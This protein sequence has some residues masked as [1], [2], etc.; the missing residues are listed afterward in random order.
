MPAPRPTALSEVCQTLIG[1]HRPVEFMSVELPGPPDR[2]RMSALVQL[3]VSIHWYRAD[4]S[5]AGNFGQAQA[6]LLQ[7]RHVLHLACAVL[8]RRFVK[9]SAEPPAFPRCH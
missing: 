5:A 4:D 7:C 2:L 8:Y 9:T 6:L 3:T 1:G